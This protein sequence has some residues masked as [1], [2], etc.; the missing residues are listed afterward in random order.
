MKPNDHLAHCLSIESLGKEILSILAAAQAFIDN[1]GGFKRSNALSNTTLATL[2]FEPSTR[3]RCSFELAARYLG[4]NVINLD[5]QTSAHQK[6]ETLLDTVNNLAAMGVE[7]F[8]IRHAESGIPETIANQVADNIHIINAGD[9]CHAH[10]TQALGDMLTLQQHQPDFSQLK[11]AIIG[12][13]AHSRVAR[14]QIQALSALG[15]GEIRLIAPDAFMPT[16]LAQLPVTTHHTL[17][18][19]LD[20]AN[21]IITLRIQKERI[22]ES[23]NISFES[24]AHEYGIN[25]ENLTRCN[26]DDDFIILHPGP[27]NRGVELSSTLADHPQH[28]LILKQVRNG[29][30]ARMAILSMLTRRAT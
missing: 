25:E 27:I 4:A 10:P 2:F 11:V 8:A 5:T 12:D 30:A 22:K 26:P 19:G 16:D 18:S 20:G 17:A 7:L 21:V 23:N 1:N 28:A 24:F 13:I 3:T 29:I 14:S 6:G 9:G 15:A